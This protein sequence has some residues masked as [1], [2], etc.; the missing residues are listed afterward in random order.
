M[1]DSATPRGSGIRIDMLIVAVVAALGLAAVTYVLSQRQQEL[2]SSP[3]GLDGLQIYLTSQRI[4]SQVF[5]GGWVVDPNPIGL[6]V[7]PLHDTDP[8]TDLIPPGTK[9]EL[10]FQQDESD[11][12]WD[13]LRGKLD[14]MPGLVV[15]PK[16]RSG[17]RLTGIA[18]PALLVDGARVELVLRGLTGDQSMRVTRS[19]QVFTALPYTGTAG[20][21]Y[22]TDLYAAQLFT[23]PSCTPIIGMREAALLAS[24][25]L[26]GS[27]K[28]VMVLSDPDLL[29][30][31]GLRLGDNA[32]I[33]RDVLR[34]LAGDDTI[35]VDYSR[36]DWFADSDEPITH[37]RTWADLIRLFQPPFRALW[38]GAG[39]LLA[40][41]LWR[42]FRRAGPVSESAGAVLDKLQAIQA[43]A[44]LMR[45][46]GQDGTMLGDYAAARIAAT[47]ARLVGPGQARLIGEEQAFLRFVARR[48][49]DLSS[50][51]A[52]VLT[53]LH[54]LPKRV[55]A[56]VAIGHIDELERILELIAHDT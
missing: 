9:E 48:S 18:H 14:R 33:A 19:R 20:E 42:S 16:W 40:L 24:C 49:A 31:H 3:V 10:L 53:H 21:A 52:T 34:N 39:F 11:Q 15:L 25:P 17:M 6:L 1:T 51:L 4:N 54:D 44:R 43:R 30:N 46:T 7:L 56:A 27:T 13:T 35:F 36:D 26:R 2:R 23:A 41:V 8:S 22:K 50:R 28:R 45:L 32:V 55:P 38:L 12:G 37:E 29:N 5:S 47:A